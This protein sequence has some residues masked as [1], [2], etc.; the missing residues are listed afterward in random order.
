[1]LLLLQYQYDI[2]GLQARGLVRLAA[3]GDLL[4][5]LHALIY[6]D[7]QDLHFLHHLLTLAFFTAVF[8]ID[9]FACT[10]GV[11]NMNAPATPCTTAELEEFVSRR[12][13]RSSDK[14]LDNVRGLGW[15]TAG[16]P[17]VHQSI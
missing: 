11:E 9:D 2:S 15:E 4:A 17:L 14:A 10:Q 1:M 7:L 12:G 3:E 5:V 6:V 8:L 13:G 16:S